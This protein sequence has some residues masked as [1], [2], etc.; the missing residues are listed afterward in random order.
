MNIKFFYFLIKKFNYLNYLKHLN[1]FNKKFNYL[2]YL[3]HLILKKSFY[4]LNEN[5]IK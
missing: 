1:F 3:K 2:N 4:I 5:K